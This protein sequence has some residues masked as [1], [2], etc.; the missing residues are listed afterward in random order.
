MNFLNE[1]NAKATAT[2]SGG[3]KQGDSCDARNATRRTLQYVNRAI[4][5]GQA[6]DGEWC[7]NAKKAITA[8]ANLYGAT[9][10]SEHN[11]LTES[12]TKT[13]NELRDDLNTCVSVLDSK[14]EAYN[15]MIAKAKAK[16]A[17]AK[18]N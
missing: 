18:K 15:A 10:G 17:K 14:I 6:N 3:T 1:A 8:M 2:K 4:N 9:L 11:P 5:N 13:I 7:K 16:K 12:N